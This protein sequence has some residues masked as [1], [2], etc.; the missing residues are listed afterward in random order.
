MFSG[1]HRLDY[2]AYMLQGIVNR[3]IDQIV[4]FTAKD[5]LEAFQ[6][7]EARWPE[8]ITEID[9]TDPLRADELQQLFEQGF[10]GIAGRLWPKLQRTLCFGAGKQRANMEKLRFYTKCT[11]HNHGYFITAES[12]IAKAI[13]DDSDDFKLILNNNVYEFVPVGAAQDCRPLLLTETELGKRYELVVTNK[14]GLYRFKTKHQMIIKEKR[15]IEGVF[16]TFD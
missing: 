8:M 11:P 14:S 2:Y 12:L 1:D 4:G 16:I 3:N 15:G 9:K 13:G 5:L 7:L 6:V 10:D